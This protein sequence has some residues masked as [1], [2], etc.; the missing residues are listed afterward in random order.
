MALGK[1][2]K[3][4]REARGLSQQAIADQLQ[5]PPGKP[6]PKQ[7]T[8]QNIESRDNDSSRYED[9]LAK[10]L[11]VPFDWLKY[12]IGSDPFTNETT[13][14]VAPD[15]SPAG[16]HVNLSTENI[17]LITSYLKMDENGFTVQLIEAEKTHGVKVAMDTAN[18]VAYQLIGGNFPMPFRD[19]WHLIIKS[20]QQPHE[21]ELIII[22]KTD[23]SFMIGE[24]LF[25]K[26]TSIDII[27]VINHDRRTILLAEIGEILPITAIIS[28]SQRVQ[29]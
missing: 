27:S 23:G 12:G 19:G 24:Y 4:A 6:Q 7:G 13:N 28:P 18:L 5:P 2:L 3:Q 15:L 9:Q 10:I 22:K 29:L 14:F 1:R 25:S 17:V 26:N 16:F 20:N 8:I 11:N 21:G